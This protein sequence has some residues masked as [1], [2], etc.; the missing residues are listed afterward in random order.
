MAMMAV[1]FG[2]GMVILGLWGGSYLT[3]VFALDA[4]ERGNVLLL[5]ALAN[6]VGLIL[7]G[8][9]DQLLNSR[10][11]VVV[12][13]GCG[14]VAGF[15]LL[16][17][18]GDVNIWLSI[19]LMIMVMGSQGYYVALQT[20]CRSLFPDHMVGRANTMMNLAGVIGVF[21]MQW[22]TGLIIDLFPIDSGIADAR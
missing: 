8:P 6:P 20:H 13:A 11:K 18:L 5:L 7:I 9:L 14:L 16:A 2:P 21:A 19:A 4:L 22:G 15:L 3:D 17:L 1:T 12:G 10:R